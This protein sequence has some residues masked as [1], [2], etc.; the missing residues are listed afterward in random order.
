MSIAACPQNG[1][2]KESRLTDS[3]FPVELFRCPVCGASFHKVEN[4][5]LCN[6]ARCHCFDFSSCGYVNL[7]TSAQSNGGDSKEAVRA[8][9]AFLR[10]GYYRQAAD[11]I[12]ETVAAY[13]PANGTVI[14][15]GCGEG[16]YAETVAAHGF[17]VVGFD[18]S[19]AACERAAKQVKAN[20]T[21]RFR[22]KFAVAG[23]FSLPLQDA[24][25][26]AV[27]NVF[28]PCAETEY[29]RILKPGGIL[30][31]AGAGEKHL[32]GLKKAIYENPYLNT[33]RADLPRF[34][35]LTDKKHACFSVTLTDQA[36]IA[37]L[38]SMTP[39]YWR[40][41]PADREKLTALTT[42]TTEIDFEI[43]VYRK[44]V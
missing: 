31:V 34:M 44:E 40:T 38:F 5:L 7:A 33:P 27:I 15:A 14:D 3:E 11:A 36:S 41:G 1:Q 35:T 8:R 43:S 17:R 32:L 10:S 28:A 24:C 42:L 25:A 4:S 21:L 22:P 23:V 12:A 19:K 6:G 13:V 29:A 20:Q 2:R 16:Y 18:L 37:A 26:D 39:Y 30:L 9:S